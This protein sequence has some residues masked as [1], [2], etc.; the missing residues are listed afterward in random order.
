MSTSPSLT[1]NWNIDTPENRAA[2]D[3]VTRPSSYFTLVLWQ[4]QAGVF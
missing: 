3:A 2:W 4:L 1:A